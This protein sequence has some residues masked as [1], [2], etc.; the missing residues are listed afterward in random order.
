MIEKINVFI[1][2][3]KR[4]KEAAREIA[5][6]LIADD[7]SVWLDEWEVAAG[8]SI[9]NEIN[10][11]LSGCSHFI[12]LWSMNAAKSNWVKKELNSILYKAIQNGIP[13][14]I[15][16]LSDNTELPELLNDLKYIRYKNGS[17]KD[18]NEI[19]M[20]IKGTRPSQNFINAVFK[21]YNEL[22]Y[23]TDTEDPLPFKI[24]PNCGSD[25][26]ERSSATDY[27]HDETYFMIRC[28]D[29]DWSDWTQ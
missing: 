26:L 21:K 23:D 29:C 22:I 27:Q 14:I 24:C 11:G 19:I 25:K 13:K 15:P 6:F 18:R 1:S 7:I 8:D 28:K 16:I 4:D 5:L 2:Y 10:A 3:N 12:I 20:A 17:E 9:I